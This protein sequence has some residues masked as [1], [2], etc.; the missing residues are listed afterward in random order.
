MMAQLLGIWMFAVGGAAGFSLFALLITIVM[1]GP[2]PSIK[3]TLHC[4]AVG[5]AAGLLIEAG[6]FFATV[7]AALAATL[8]ASG[9]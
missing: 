4:L 9:A 7:W 6:G 3:D 1:H 2:P 5:F 8:L